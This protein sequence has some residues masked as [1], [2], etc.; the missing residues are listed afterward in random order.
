MTPWFGLSENPKSCAADLDRVAHHNVVKQGFAKIHTPGFGSKRWESTLPQASLCRHPRKHP[1]PRKQNHPDLGKVRGDNENDH[2]EDN[3]FVEDYNDDDNV[4]C[5]P[6]LFGGSSFHPLHF[7]PN[8]VHLWP[9]PGNCT[10]ICLKNNINQTERNVMASGQESNLIFN[11]SESP[12]CWNPT[13]W[14]CW[15]SARLSWQV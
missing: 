10:S 13:G 9:C 11:L 7:K 4:W 6:G 2:H 5:H 1:Q 3:I 15:A 8:R 12:I 14:W